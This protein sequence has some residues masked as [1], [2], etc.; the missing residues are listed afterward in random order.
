MT[1]K[2]GLIR[3]A[4]ATI[5]GL[6]ILTFLA[7]VD[8]NGPTAEGDYYYVS[9]GIAATVPPTT[10]EAL[11]VTTSSSAPTT[12]IMAPTTT[13]ITA[14]PGAWQCPNAIALAVTVGWPATE[15]DTLDAII[16]RE[17]RCDGRQHNQADPASGS[18]GLLQINGYWCHTTRWL[19][20]AGVLQRCADLFDDVTSLRA[21]LTIWNNSGWNPWGGRP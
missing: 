4:I 12:T 1:T 21:G 5:T 10:A 6:A 11:E 16:W 14:P 2:L 19:Q 17:S 18:R 8:W 15:L 13:A 20:D 9:A 3:L 7:V